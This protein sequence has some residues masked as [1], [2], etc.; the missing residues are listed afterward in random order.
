MVVETVH[1]Q[2]RIFVDGDIRQRL[3]LRLFSLR[4]LADLVHG[5]GAFCDAFVAEGAIGISL[6]RVDEEHRMYR[7]LGFAA[8]R[9]K[10]GL[11]L[12]AGTVTFGPQPGF[13]RREIF[14]DAPPHV[15]SFSSSR[16]PPRNS[17]AFPSVGL[18]LDA[19]TVTFGPQPGFPRREIFRDAPPHV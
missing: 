10:H 5:V 4:L 9:V 15:S 18:T 11:T 14:R 1:Q 2:Q 16:L 13:P 3:L 8:A 19:G 7:R 12:D 6:A 17:R